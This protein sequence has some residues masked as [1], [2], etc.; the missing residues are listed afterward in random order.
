MKGFHCHNSIHICSIPWTCS[1]LHYI[2]IPF[3]LLPYSN[4]VWW[5]SFVVFICVCVAFLHPLHP[6][7]S[8]PLSLLLPLTPQTVPQIHSWPITTPDSAPNTLMTHHPPRQCPNTLM[9][10]HHHFRSRFHK[11]ARTCDIWLFEFC[12]S[13]QRDDL[14]F[15]PFSCKWHN[16]IFLYG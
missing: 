2:S 4:S 9:T 6:S 5:V 1:P 3:F 16:F 10:H 12:L 13:L 15:H 14:Q 7:V 8:F 11:S